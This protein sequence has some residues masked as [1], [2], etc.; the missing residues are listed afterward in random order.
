M[1][2]F[3]LLQPRT[4]YGDT[5]ISLHQE[6]P[7]TYYPNV[8]PN[9]NSMKSPGY[10]SYPMKTYDSPVYASP[11]VT[12]NAFS[13]QTGIF[14]QA[15]SSSQDLSTKHLPL[16]A[17][18]NKLEQKHSIVPTMMPTGTSKREVDSIRLEQQTNM[19]Q[20]AVEPSK[21]SVEMKIGEQGSM[22]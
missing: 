9:L 2:Y 7:H 3:F 19:Q 12:V 13:E 20:Q 6:R 17:E 15:Q 18:N 10:S 11:S 4:T 5:V 16:H 22:M 8:Y 14:R 1:S 21:T